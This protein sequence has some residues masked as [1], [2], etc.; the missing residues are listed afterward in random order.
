MKGVD[1]IYTDS[2]EWSIPWTRGAKILHIELRRWADIMIIAPLSANTLSKMA[3]G[4]CDN[5]LL[6]TIRAW[7]T[8][9]L[10][11]PP[12]TVTLPERKIATWPTNKR[13]IIVVAPAMNTAMWAHP[14]TKKHISVLEEEWSTNVK[15]GWIEVMRPME[16]ELACGDTGTGAMI[17]WEVVVERVRDI[18][19]RPFWE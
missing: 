12:H 7:D 4:L 11:D 5:L 9:R 19:L 15:G 10:L 1:G 17:S 3:V 6:S 8:T 13:K 14:I 2:D 18:V 16:K